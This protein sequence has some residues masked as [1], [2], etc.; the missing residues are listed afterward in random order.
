[1]YQRYIHSEQETPAFRLW[2]I[3][4]VLGVLCGEFLTAEG[5]EERGGKKIQT[6]VTT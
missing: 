1:L 2:M 3:C 6:E 4:C 5:A